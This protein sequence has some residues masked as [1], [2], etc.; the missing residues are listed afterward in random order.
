MQIAYFMQSLQ[1]LG[2]LN[3]DLNDCAKGELG[4]LLLHNLQVGA[5]LLHR[6]VLMTFWRETVCDKCWKA[7]DLLV[8]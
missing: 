1:T 5:Q 6:D 3:S 4:D 8:F 2:Q 7:P